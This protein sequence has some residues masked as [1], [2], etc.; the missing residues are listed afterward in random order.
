MLRTLILWSIL[1]SF[2]N[3]NVLG[4]T[5]IFSEDFD[6][7]TVGSGIVSQSGAPWGTWSGAIGSEDCM[8]S[9]AQ[10]YSG[11]QSL[12][13]NPNNDIVLSLGDLTTGRYKLEFS[14]FVTANRLAYFNLLSNFNGSNS[15]WATQSYFLPDG[16]GAIDADGSSSGI[17]SYTPNS[18]FPVYYIIDLDDD[19][20]SFFINGTEVI[21]WKYSRGT[22]G[23]EGLLALDAFNLYGW[24]EGTFTS[25]FYIDD[26]IFSELTA[27][28][29]ATNLI[30]N[31]INNNTELSWDAPSNS[32]P[33]SYLLTRFNKSFMNGIINTSFIDSNP[34]PNTYTFEVRAHYPGQGYSHASNTASVTIP[35][36]VERD[37]VLLE[38]N[39]GT[40]C[41]FCP[42]AA[43]GADDAEENELNMAIIKY[44][45]NDNYTNSDATLRENYYAVSGFPT[46]SVDGIKRYEG[47]SAS[48]TLYPVYEEFYNERINY[49]SVITMNLEASHIDGSIFSVSINIQEENTYFGN[50]LKLHTALTESHIAH[51]WGPMTEVNS[52]CRKMYPDGLGANIIWDS[53]QQYSQSYT[54]NTE[55]Y[56]IDH[57]EVI[58]FIQHDASREVIQ[59]QKI[60]LSS[61]IQIKD[62]AATQFKIYPNPSKGLVNIDIQSPIN[63]VYSIE[64]IDLNGKSI[65][66]YTSGQ[67]NLI[68]K[69]LDLSALDGGLYFIK[70]SNHNESFMKRIQIL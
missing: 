48:Q 59:T 7:L 25:Q 22:F 10:A 63:E 49:P 57:C 45:N 61:L 42:G 24:A 29:S 50:D 41:G 6:N 36:G 70:I 20:A 14:L 5:V 33:E 12:L 66:T 34:Y 23:T 69:Q 16:T 30:A 11:T 28:E 38:I 46:S 56:N 3:L 39:T 35:G 64:V 2:L 27:P 51:V 60:K 68:S 52:V 32:T 4:Q 1:A 26:L 43:M 47:G 37:L 18:W 44:H 17:F 31:Q 67:A 65:R 13:I 40:W 19:F 21:S 15:E 54:V 9:M 8:V 53:N 62:L 58:S 55:E